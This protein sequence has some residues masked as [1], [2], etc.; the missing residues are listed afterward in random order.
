MTFQHHLPD[1]S[2]QWYWI[3]PTASG[4]LRSTDSLVLKVNGNTGMRLLV[5][6]HAVRSLT[7]LPGAVE[8]E[9]GQWLQVVPNLAQVQ[10][11]RARLFALVVNRNDAAPHTTLVPVTMQMEVGEVQ[12]SLVMRPTI[13]PGHH[14]FNFRTNGTLEGPGLFNMRDYVQNGFRCVHGRVIESPRTPRQLQYSAVPTVTSVREDLAPNWYVIR[15]LTSVDRYVLH[16]GCIPWGDCSLEATSPTGNFNITLD[17]S[18]A[19]NP[20]FG[21]WMAVHYSIREDTYV[22]GRL[23]ESHTHSNEHDSVLSLVLY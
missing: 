22:Y 9:P 16:Y 23:V 19:P 12:N 20:A 8:V 5:A 4:G 2:A 6:R 3:R 10:S 13:V 14:G 18:N 1:L 17:P 21:S 11:D 7:W 15:T